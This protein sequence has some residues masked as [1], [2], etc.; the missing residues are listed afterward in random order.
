MIIRNFLFRAGQYLR[1]NQARLLRILFYALIALA[2]VFLIAGGV[3]RWQKWRYEK[4]VNALEDKFHEASGHAKELQR[5][6]DELK[7]KLDAK[8]SEVQFWEARSEAAEQRMGETRV[9]YRTLKDTYEETRLN[10]D[11]PADTTC[12]D[13]CAELSRLGHACK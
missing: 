9:V 11:V 12:A 13:A 8:Q 2:A 3:S 10:P 5:E 6:A 1:D 4:R 7:H